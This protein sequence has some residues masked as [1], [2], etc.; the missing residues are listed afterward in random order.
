ME[1]EDRKHDGFVIIVTP[2]KNESDKLS[3]I[4]QEAGYMVEYAD[5]NTLLDTAANLNPRLILLDADQSIAP[6]PHPVLDELYNNLQ[7]RNI[8]IILL[9]DA[10]GRFDVTVW[11][12]KLQAR[13]I[14]MF[15]KFYTP[16]QLL[17]YIDNYF[18]ALDRYPSKP[19]EG[20]R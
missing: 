10:K 20:H 15:R 19:S 3:A 12:P 13:R 9:T 7:T 14:P 1:Q 17:G 5:Y 6:D 2:D 11:L 8:P 4:L 16:E 18:L